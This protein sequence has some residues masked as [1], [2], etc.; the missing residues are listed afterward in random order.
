MIDAALALDDS[1]NSEAHLRAGAVSAG[2]AR[3]RR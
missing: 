3:F 2:P 1:L